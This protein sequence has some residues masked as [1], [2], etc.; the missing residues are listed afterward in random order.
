[1]FAA[2]G[3]AA[4][5][6]V[7]QLCRQRGLQ[8]RVMWFD[9][10]ANLWALS[11]RDRVADIVQQCK[12]ANINTIVVDVKPLSGLVLYDSKIAPKLTRFEGRPYPRDYDLLRTVIEEAHKVGIPVHAAINVFSEGSQDTPGGP[13]LEHK[14]WQC[15]QYDI[16]RSVKAGDEPKRA[17]KSA[18]YPYSSGDVCVYGDDAK[19]IG[20]LPPNTYYVRVD[21]EG[22]TLQSEAVTGRARLS[23]PE[24]G[25][26]LVGN[27]GAGVW[28]RDMVSSGAKFTLEC[29]E[30][31]KPV[32]DLNNVHAAVFVNPLHPEARAHELSVIKEIC[33]NYPV[34][35]IVLDRMRFPNIYTDFSD[36]SRKAFEQF[37]GHPV[38]NWP[39][40]VF[41][42]SAVPS[43]EVVRGPLFKSWLKFRAKV[44]HDFLAEARDVV[45]KTKPNAKLG[46]YVGSWY[47]LY[48]DVGV[49]WGSSKHSTDY[50][51]WPEGYEETGFADLADYLCTGCYYT[52]PT[53]SEARAN[54]EEEWKSVAAA[55]EES[56]KAVDD[57]TFVYGSLY[58]RQYNGRPAKFRE[59]I[60]Q[61]LEK[62]QGCMFFDLVHVRDYGWWDEIGQVFNQPTRAPHEVPE[63]LDELR[64]K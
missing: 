62:T 38:E 7:N 29:N 48:Y 46:V 27:R 41:K 53:R 45:K 54:G 57:A 43:T 64:R 15:V 24:G 26:V 47:P 20:E 40:D 14:D 39:A 44:I 25:F 36:T 63:L 1:M 32:G 2:S 13:A 18:G 34:D 59:A 50:E 6:R 52:Y 37:I 22:R 8:G 16:E 33:E 17:V 55:A 61:C 5:S 42:R 51:W 11:S 4:D 3:V 31:M 12:A 19:S 30:T 28:L 35:G 23:A 9:A 56:I 21:K 60:K 10:E 58:L 49:N